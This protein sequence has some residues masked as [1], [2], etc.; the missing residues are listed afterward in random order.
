ML[1]VYTNTLPNYHGSKVRMAITTFWWT[2]GV[3]A[4]GRTREI[5]CF[6][7]PTRQHIEQ[8]K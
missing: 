2:V 3:V 4:A 6:I 8:C 5:N 7:L 1:L